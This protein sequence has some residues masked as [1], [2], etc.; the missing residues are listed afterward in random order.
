MKFPPAPWISNPEALRNLL[1]RVRPMVAVYA[2]SIL[3]LGLAFTGLSLSG[4]F[5]LFFILMPSFLLSLK[6][7]CEIAWDTSYKD[8]WRW[9]KYRARP[10]SVLLSVA[11]LSSVIL[12][13]HVACCFWIYFAALN[14]E[15]NYIS[16]GL[17][18]FVLPMYLLITIVAVTVLY[19]PI[20]L[21]IDALFSLM[22]IGALKTEAW[23]QNL[24]I[25][26]T[27]HSILEWLT[28]VGGLCASIPFFMIV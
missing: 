1:E 17:F 20:L 10:D 14:N 15:I 26:T 3:S 8:T 5:F 4:F 19:F 27:K 18:I 21:L 6:V 13:L 12:A 23:P 16:L 2:T 24:P 11:L 25:G 7:I 22:R 9:L 28:L